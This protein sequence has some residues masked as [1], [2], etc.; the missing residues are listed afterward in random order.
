MKKTLLLL[1]GLSLAV[2]C[3]C[4]LLPGRFTLHV[5]GP[6]TT[7]YI[8]KHEMTGWSN[9]ENVEV[10]KLIFS[11][12]ASADGSFYKLVGD[13]VFIDYWTSP[14]GREIRL[15]DLNNKW[16]MIFEARYNGGNGV[17]IDADTMYFNYWF[18]PS[19][20]TGLVCSNYAEIQKM[21]WNVNV[22]YMQKRSYNF[23]THELK[24]LWEIYCGYGE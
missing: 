10:Y 5:S 22:I 16:K 15:F 24:N 23:R 21:W 3:G 8:V 9:A 2:L 12:P 4:S 17:Q 11:K 7:T 18:S 6:Y 1:F 13:I 19:S 20:T 14:E